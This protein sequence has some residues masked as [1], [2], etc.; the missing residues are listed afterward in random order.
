MNIVVSTLDIFIRILQYLIIGRAILSWLPL[1]MD[2]PIKVIIYKLTEP[3]LGPVK[4]LLD[5]SIFGRGNSVV[6][7]SPIIAYMLLSLAR[8]A[9][10]TLIS[11]Y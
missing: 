4:S 10:F 3:I 5:R 8:M 11:I 1:D 7:F 6:D 2:H 9:L